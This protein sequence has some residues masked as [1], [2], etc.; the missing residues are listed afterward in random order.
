MPSWTMVNE[1]QYINIREVASRVLRGALTQGLQL[2]SVVQYTVDFIG[3]MGLPKMYFDK[4]V[5]LEIEDYRA[6]LPC[7][8][9]AINMVKHHGHA[10]RSMTDSFFTKEHKHGWMHYHGH[11]HYECDVHEETFKTQGQVL[12]TSFK[13]GK[14]QVSYKAI[15]V[16]E[17]GFPLIPDIPEFLKALE[18]YIRVQIFQDL[19]FRDKIDEKKLAKAEQI[20]ALAAGQ[21]QSAFTIPSVS[22]ME[23]ITRMFNTLIPRQR[24]FDKGFRSLGNR[25]YIR[26]Q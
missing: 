6:A 10:L 15:P 26:K 3:I 21:C 9:I 17:E 19:Y 5:T 23:S 8:L 11:L 2:E 14:V 13:Q 24:E 18:G 4:E 20:Y 25:E 1:I 16:D 12:Y 22:E 7:D